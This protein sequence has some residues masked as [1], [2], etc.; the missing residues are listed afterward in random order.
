LYIEVRNK[1]IS[2]PLQDVKKAN[3]VYEFEN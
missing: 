3:L 2:L 1:L